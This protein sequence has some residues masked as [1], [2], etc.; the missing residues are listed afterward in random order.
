MHELPG[1][2][3]GSLP[4]YASHLP[5]NLEYSLVL[6][7]LGHYHLYSRD[8]EGAVRLIHSGSSG[9]VL[10]AFAVR[11]GFDVQELQRDLDSI[12]MDFAKNFQE[13]LAQ[14]GL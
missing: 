2:Y 1:H 14:R 8:A 13:F 4:V 6:D 3:L 12:D 5:W 7:T 9:R 11:N 10:A